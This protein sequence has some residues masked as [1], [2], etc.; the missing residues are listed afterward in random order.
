MAIEHNCR[1]NNCDIHWT[2]DHNPMGVYDGELLL[3]VK[4]CVY[5]CT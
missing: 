1:T 3:Q 5:T 2:T 4:I